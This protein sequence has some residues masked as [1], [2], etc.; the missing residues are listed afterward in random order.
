MFTNTRSRSNSRAPEARN[1]S[2]SSKM[3]KAKD[4]VTK[5]SSNPSSVVKAKTDDGEPRTTK[6]K[7]SESERLWP[8]QSFKFRDYPFT[9]EVFPSGTCDQR[10]KLLPL[11]SHDIMNQGNLP[12]LKTAIDLRQ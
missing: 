2:D 11:R 3:K 6:K 1:G 8:G 9:I 4:T 7:H 12:P 5:M 10:H